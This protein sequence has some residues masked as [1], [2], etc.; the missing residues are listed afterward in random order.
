[1]IHVIAT[2]QLAPGRRADFLREFHA[3]MPSVKSEQGCIEYGPA[4]DLASGLDAQSALRPE[5]VV[6]VEKWVSL[7]A[8]EKHLAA[9]HMLKY[10]EKVKQL[11]IDVQLQ[12]L[13]PA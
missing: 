5:T 4:V 11:V 7:A 9:P 6:V 10:R 1:M 2:I 3:L 12:V 13:E 8:L